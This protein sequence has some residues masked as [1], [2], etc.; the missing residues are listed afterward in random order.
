MLKRNII[1]FS[2]LDL[3]TRS[4]ALVK[5]RMVSTGAQAPSFIYKLALVRKKGRRAPIKKITQRKKIYF[6]EAIFDWKMVTVCVCGSVIQRFGIVKLHK[7]WTSSC[8]FQTYTAIGH[9][10]MYL[11]ISLT[12]SPH[13]INREKSLLTLQILRH[14]AWINSLTYY[15]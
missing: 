8:Y 5:R 6:P 13:S 7:L 1:Y 2:R 11:Y 10:K 3:S 14:S 4:G 15:I 9:S 12:A